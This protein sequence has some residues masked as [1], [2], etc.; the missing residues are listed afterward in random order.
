[1]NDNLIEK[2]KNEMMNMYRKR[3]VP[4]IAPTTPVEVDGKGAIIAIVT[5]I[6]NLY[7][8]QNAKVTIFTGDMDNMNIIE[9]IYTDSSGRTKEIVLSAPPRSLSQEVSEN[10]QVYSLYNM[11]VE[12]DGYLDNFHLNIPVFSGVTSLQR[13][14]LLL[15]ETAGVNRDFLL[16]DESSRY[17]L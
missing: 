3:V 14:N 5:T 11:R 9:E 2:Y 17:D 1:M 10:K 6:K 12:A 13:S 7:P 16:F 4:T 15:E 8:V